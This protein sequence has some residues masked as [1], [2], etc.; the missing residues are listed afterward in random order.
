M[1]DTR[2]LADVKGACREKLLKF[3]EHSSFQGVV[4]RLIESPDVF[5]SHPLLECGAVLGQLFSLPCSSLSDSTDIPP[6]LHGSG[7][8]LD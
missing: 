6:V 2:A 5:P 1:K 3:F 8:C 7:R 4:F